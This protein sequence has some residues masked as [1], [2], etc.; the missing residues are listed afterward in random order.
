MLCPSH[1]AQEPTVH[2]FGRQHQVDGRRRGVV[3]VKAGAVGIY[4]TGAAGCDGQEERLTAAGLLQ[5]LCRQPEAACCNQQRQAHV[6]GAIAT[7]QCLSRRCAT[8]ATSAIE[9]AIASHRLLHP[10]VQ[11][12]RRSCELRPETTSAVRY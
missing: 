6:Q 11:L 5:Q 1:A 2:N 9:A 3:A 12:R 7:Q 8:A 4:G 10:P